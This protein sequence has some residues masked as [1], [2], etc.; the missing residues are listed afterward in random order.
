MSPALLPRPPVPDRRPRR[1]TTLVELLLALV[2][3]TV[4]LLG[5]AGSAA[6]VARELG[7]SRR[8]AAVTAAARNRL[9]RVTSGPCRSPDDGT[10]VG[11]GI[12]ERW[13]VVPASSGMSRVAVTA[14]QRAPERNRSTIRRLEALVPCL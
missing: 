10:A 11:A 8:E 14:E 3:V 5:L 1:G 12:V 9:E 6:L 2:V 4:G 7:A 13:T